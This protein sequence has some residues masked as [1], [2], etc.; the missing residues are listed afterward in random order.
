MGTMKFLFDDGVLLTEKMY[1][2]TVTGKTF[3]D[4]FEAKESLNISA[5]KFR[6]FLRTRRLLV[7]LSAGEKYE[8]TVEEYHKKQMKKD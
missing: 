5:H 1:F 4:R 3:K 8:E 2:D 6:E 7:V